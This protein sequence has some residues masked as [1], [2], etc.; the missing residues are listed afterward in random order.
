MKIK[1][2]IIAILTINI[3][4]SQNKEIKVN[5]NNN[6][7]L[8]FNSPITRG[9][10][11]NSNFIFSYNKDNLEKIGLLKGNKTTKPTNLL[12]TTADGLIYS[13]TIAYNE[14]VNKFNYFIKEEEAIN[15]KE[16]NTVKVANSDP[17][18]N[19]NSQPNTKP[20]TK[21]VEKT[22]IK[23]AIPEEIEQI[24]KKVIKNKP[25]YLRSVIIKND[26]ILRLVSINYKNNLLY[27]TY[28]IKNE[29]LIDLDIEYLLFRIKNKNL[30]M[31]SSSQAI[32]IQPLYKFN[33]PK[34]LK[35]NTTNRFV[36]AFE[37]FTISNKKLFETLIK[38]DNGERDIEI[39][40]S[41]KMIIN[42]KKLK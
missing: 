8:F 2:I 31:Q 12:I 19:S 6:V 10:T 20:N 3:G 38:E 25:F 27:F 34:K 37:K 13:F 4:Y 24:C 41:K 17:L 33:V 7:Y 28:E 1:L 14:Y 30:K 22:T 11:G 42:P 29:G 16:K 26:L 35:G 36:V 21:E 39:T 9:L 5:L 18:I 40:A 32:D 23:T 15:F